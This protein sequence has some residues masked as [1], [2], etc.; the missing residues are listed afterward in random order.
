MHMKIRGV[1]GV[2]VEPRIV[3]TLRVSIPRSALPN[4]PPYVLRLKCGEATVELK[5]SSMST[6]TAIYTVPQYAQEAV[7][8]NATIC[9]VIQ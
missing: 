2:E 4:P 5:L 7:L 1:N 8:S 3:T 6:N 9:T